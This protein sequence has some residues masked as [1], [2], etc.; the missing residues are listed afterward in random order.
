MDLVKCSDKDYARF[1]A[2]TPCRDIIPYES[3]S[4]KGSRFGILAIS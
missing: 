2:M 4:T 3:G 1:L